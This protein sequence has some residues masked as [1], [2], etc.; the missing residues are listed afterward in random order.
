[1]MRLLADVLVPRIY[2]APWGIAPVSFG[3]VSLLTAPRER[4]ARGLLRSKSSGETRT[5][6][7]GLSA[8]ELNS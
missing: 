6:E 5:Y 7:L 3:I 8:H 4:R 1:M 2:E